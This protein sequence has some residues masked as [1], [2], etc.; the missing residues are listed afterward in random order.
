MTLNFDLRSP[1][2]KLYRYVFEKLNE[3][4]YSFCVGVIVGPRMK[5]LAYLMDPK[6]R[7][8]HLLSTFPTLTNQSC[9]VPINESDNTQ[10]LDPQLVAPSPPSSSSSNISN[11]PGASKVIPE[12]S[13]SNVLCA[14]STCTVPHISPTKIIMPHSNSENL[15][16]LEELK[17]KLSKAVLSEKYES[18]MFKP[19]KRE[20]YVT[21]VP[22][23]SE[24]KLGKGYKYFSTLDAHI[25]RASHTEAVQRMEEGLL[26]KRR[27][28]EEEEENACDVGDTLEDEVD[29]LTE[30]ERCKKREEVL[31]E[32]KNKFDEKLYKVE[33]HNIVCNYCATTLAIFPKRGNVIHN[34]T[35]HVESASHIKESNTKKKQMT[36]S[37]FFTVKK[38]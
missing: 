5:I 26:R 21:C 12:E 11:S 20:K 31:Q 37:T 10:I 16:P 15:D 32:V 7:G 35:T 6:A 13:V 17:I 36:L 8:A 25:K 34:M 29:E 9:S 23:R 1:L 28:V 33:A 38:D 3:L 2:K 30:D 27:L 24:Y 18:G 4:Y 22:C 19:R 14:A